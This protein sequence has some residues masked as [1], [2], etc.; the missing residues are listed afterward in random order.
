MEPSSNLEKYYK[1]PLHLDDCM[2]YVFDSD[3]RMPMMYAMIGRGIN[4]N[5][6]TRL[7]PSKLISGN[8]NKSPKGKFVKGDLGEIDYICEDSKVIK[9]IFLI[10]GWGKL[11]GVGGYRLDSS[12]AAEIQDEFREYFINLL[13]NSNYE[14]S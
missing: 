14:T 5:E 13:N 1:F 3:E 10:R 9:G 12:K 7:I 8:S 2:S 4:F 11:T 6:K